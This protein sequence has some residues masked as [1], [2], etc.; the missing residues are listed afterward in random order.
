LKSARDDNNEIQITGI[1]GKACVS[2]VYIN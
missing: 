1:N 2:R